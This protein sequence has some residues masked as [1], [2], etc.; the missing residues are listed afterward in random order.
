MSLVV[1]LFVNLFVGTCCRFVGD[2]FVLCLFDDPLFCV[3]IFV[4]HH[5]EPFCN[6]FV[7]T[8]TYLFVLLV[9]DD[10]GLVVLLFVSR[11]CV[12]LW[13]VLGGEVFGLVLD[14]GLAVWLVA[15]LAAWL[16]AC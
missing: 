5:A 13:R 16:V 4:G 3:T 9:S 7:M 12:A 14:G 6:E 11:C 2:L 10:H 15:W 8:T 1:E